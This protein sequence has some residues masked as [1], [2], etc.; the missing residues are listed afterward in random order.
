MGNEAEKKQED[1]Q[2]PDYLSTEKIAKA[3]EKAAGLK[4]TF[5]DGEAPPPDDDET[6]DGQEGEGEGGESEEGDGSPKEEPDEVQIVSEGDTQPQQVPTGVL[7][8]FGQ[9]TGQVKE[10]KSETAEVMQRLNHVEEENKILKIALGSQQT[11]PK[12]AQRP[13]PEEF[14]SGVHDPG[15]LKAID[16]FTDKRIQEGVAQAVATATETSQATQVKSQQTL[17]FQKTLMTHIERATK[18]KVKDYEETEDKAIAIFGQENTNHLIAGLPD[19]SEVAMYYFGKNP[20]IAEHYAEMF[21][22]EPVKALIEIGRKLSKL[23]VKPV[24]S[25]DLPD[26]DEEIEGGKGPS[27]K[28][29][30]PK[31]ATFT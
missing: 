30:G 16:D 20:K 10:A 22:T 15:Y 11:A 3:G 13:N 28:K 17:G 27:K 2:N 14:D 6:G 26:P 31:G 23:K 9:M 29:R 24:K 1:E 5:D 25:S 19:D 7:K 18:L 8:R 4:F 21:K 12:P